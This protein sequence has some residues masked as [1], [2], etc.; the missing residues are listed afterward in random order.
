MCFADVVGSRADAVWWNN[1]C[2][3]EAG[4]IIILFCCICYIK[5]GCH[6]N[7]PRTFMFAETA[8]VSAADRL[9]LVLHC[10]PSRASVI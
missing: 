5:H 1:V 3:Y 9:I 4:Y 8:N 10:I 7:S 2:G 6:L